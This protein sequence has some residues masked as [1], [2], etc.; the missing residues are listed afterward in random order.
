MGLAF[1]PSTREMYKAGISKFKQFCDHH[2]RP[3]L[4]ADKETIVYFA[5]A[6]SRL[7]SLA[8]VKVYLSSVRAWH[9]LQEP[10]K[11]QSNPQTDCE[12][13]QK[14][15]AYMIS[16]RPTRQPLTKSDVIQQLRV[17]TCPLCKHDKH[18]LTAAF[19]F[20]FFGLLKVS[21]FT[22]KSKGSFDPHEHASLTSVRWGHSYFVFTI[23]SSKTDQFRHGQAVYIIKSDNDLCRL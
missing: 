11:A 7:L 2:Q 20:T 16:R 18:M 22:V 8:T 4:P 21:E 13:S 5:L 10:Y 3:A 23:K 17:P 9:Q 14:R 1:A 19:T 15:Y 12:R 6:L